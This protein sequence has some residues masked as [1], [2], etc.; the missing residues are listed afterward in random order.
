M[1]FKISLEMH[2]EDSFFKGIYCSNSLGSEMVLPIVS[3]PIV[4]TMK[5]PVTL[6]EIP[7]ACGATQKQV[8]DYC[9]RA[10]TSVNVEDVNYILR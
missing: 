10:E 4:E 6:G 2:F 8:D 1:V 7:L 5:Q 9:L 3:F